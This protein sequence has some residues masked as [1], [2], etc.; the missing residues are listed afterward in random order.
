MVK[1][2][3]SFIITAAGI[4]SRFEDKQTKQFKKIN[5]IPIFI[6]SLLSIRE[7]GAKYEI[8]LTINEEIKKNIIEDK[9]NKFG[10]KNINLVK[11]G[12][13]RAESVYKAFLKIKN[14]NGYVVIHDSVRPNF[15]F[16]NINK[17]IKNIKNAHGIIVASKVNDTVKKEMDNSI[18][19]TINRK[20]LW[21]AETP[22]IFKY[23]SLKKCYLEKNRIKSYTDESQLLEKKGFKIKLYEN[24]EYNSKITTL[25]DLT[26]YKKLLKNV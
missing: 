11:G 3:L 7:L 2:N 13:T 19:K 24:L 1:P 20:N 10:L 25:K 18:S 22:Q 17:I 26:I 21:L 23:S 16:K 12:Q 15:K 5:G 14:K 4:G 9:L 8:Y 6:Y